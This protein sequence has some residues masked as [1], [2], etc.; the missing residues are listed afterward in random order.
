MAR[1]NT[2]VSSLTAQ[3]GLAKIQKALATRCSAC[4]AGCG[5]TAAPTTRRA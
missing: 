1:I 2:N 5:S 3:R 4:P